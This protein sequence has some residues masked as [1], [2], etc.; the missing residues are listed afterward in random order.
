[1][2][3]EENER[4]QVRAT[5]IVDTPEDE[6]KCCNDTEKFFVFGVPLNTLGKQ[7]AVYQCALTA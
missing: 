3:Q 6:L 1:M 2:E 4:C 7:F 5:F